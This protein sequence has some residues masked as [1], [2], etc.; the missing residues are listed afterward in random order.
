MPEPSTDERSQAPRA[1]GFRRL[2]GLDRS[3]PRPDQTRRGEPLRPFTIPNLVGYL[4]LAS[5]PP[6]LVIALGSGDGRTAPAALLYLWITFGDF[7]DGFLARAT[8]QY[9]RMG[10]L[11]DPVVDRLSVLAGAAVCWHFELL[12]RWGLAIVAARELAVLALS[13]QALKRGLEI[14]INWLGR[15]GALLVFGGLF[16]TQV[17]DSWVTVALF[18]TGL[19]TAIVATVLYVR[20]GRARARAG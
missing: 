4:R 14:E 11:L 8:G 20:A 9:S 6:Y 15:I 5:I 3:G 18:Y 2:S 7:V 13:E 16:W 17:F 10:A 1:R 19:A 12:P